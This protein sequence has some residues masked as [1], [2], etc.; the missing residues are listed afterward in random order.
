M[1]HMGGRH[2]G[3]LKIT[4]GRLAWS[5]LLCCAALCPAW[6]ANTYD[7][8]TESERAF[9]AA[10]PPVTV[11]VDPD[12][13]PF[14]VLT[15]DGRHQGIA[16]DL[17]RI[18][19]ARV[20][21]QLSIVPTKDWDESIAASKSG[22]CQILSFL[23]QTPKREQWLIFTEPLFRDTNVFITREEHAPITD[24]ALLQGET[25]VFPK[26]TA[27]EERIRKDYPNLIILNTESEA[28][29]IAM[30]NDKHASMT[31]RSLIVA[32]YVIKK[33]GLF[34]LKIAGLLPN[35][36]NHLRIGVAKSQVQLRDVLAKGVQTITKQDID[37]TINHFVTINVNYSSDERIIS[38]LII[39]MILILTVGFY[40]AVRL[41]RANQALSQSSQIDALTGLPNR[42]CLNQ[43]LP[44]ESERCQRFGHKFSLIIMD[45]D[46][47][48]QVNDTFGHLIGD[49]VLMIFA[50]IVQKTCRSIDLAGRWGGEEFLIL[51]PETSLE[52]A[53]ILAERLC[54]EVRNADFPTRRQ[55]TVSAGVAELHDDDTLESLLHRADTALYQSKHDGR[56]RVTAL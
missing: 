34:N 2:W 43:R 56:N 4:L 31:M 37:E 28:E 33:E 27:M 26:G 6:A 42:S 30:V 40:W 44:A 36:E 18:V 53:H 7:I 55:Q 48:K 24:P 52:Q 21:L 1:P 25:I 46:H 23:N 22:R 9:V 49:Q 16:A 29:A 13:E 17:L 47:F 39:L 3:L 19:A 54:D 10:S 5:L 41:W 32:A 15:A 11:C 45:I 35:Y 38:G 8:L 20:G 14:E 12:W 51:C 50:K